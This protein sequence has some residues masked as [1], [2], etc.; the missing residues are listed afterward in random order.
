MGRLSGCALPLYPESAEIRYSIRF[1]FHCSLVDSLAR[2]LTQQAL[3]EVDSLLTVAQTLLTAEFVNTTG[4]LV[5]AI[6]P[7][8]TPELLKQVARLLGNASKLLT[9]DGTDQ[10]LELVNKVSP[11]I[12]ATVVGQVKNLTQRAHTLLYPNRTNTITV[13]IDGVSD[14]FPKVMQI[15]DDFKP[16]NL[17]GILP[18]LTQT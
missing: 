5:D 2:F 12:D 6:A 17:T 3:R 18:E 9:K 7:V 10:I 15:F 14:L 4:T 8:I 13:L 16:L 11:V 1:R